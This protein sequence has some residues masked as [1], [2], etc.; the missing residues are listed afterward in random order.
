[1]GQELGQVWARWF[2]CSADIDRDDLV[3]MSRQM[4]FSGGV[5]DTCSQM[6]GALVG[7]DRNAYMVKNPR[8]FTIELHLQL[9]FKTGSP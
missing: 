1:M 8:F 4:G 5:Q 2:F 7:K 3:V 6:S 9:F